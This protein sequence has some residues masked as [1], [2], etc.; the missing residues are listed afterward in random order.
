MSLAPRRR[1]A[2]TPRCP[3]T[4]VTARALTETDPGSTETTIAPVTLAVAFV[5]VSEC[6]HGGGMG[7]IIGS[8]QEPR[9]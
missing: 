7:H 1:L 4:P 2:G 3:A 5:A 9:L 6:V 8:E